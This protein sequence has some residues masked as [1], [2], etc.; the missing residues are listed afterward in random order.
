VTGGAGPRVAVVGGG[1]AGVSAAL[2][3]ADSGATVT[4]F[5]KRARL[6]GLTWS[7]SH[8]GLTMDNGQHV[9]LR[10][11]T[12]YIDFLER[13]GSW[14][15]VELQ[16][17]LDVTVLSPGP[18][19]AGPVRD[20][21]G[22]ADGAVRRSRPATATARAVLRRDRLPA[23]LHLG[24]SLLSYGLVP[25]SA[26]AR[27]AGAAL[28]LRRL[29]LDDPALDQQTFASW[30]AQ[31]G[32]GQKA[33]SALWDLIC[34]PTVNLPAERASLAMAAKVFQ[35]G[36][37]TDAS[38]GDIGWSR[39]PLGLLHGE[40]AACALRRAGVDV[41]LGETVR[42]IEPVRPGPGGS[43]AGRPA[44]G[45][46]V[47]AAGG[48]AAADGVVVAL[49]H[50]CTEDLLPPGALPDQCRPSRLAS[51]PI[52]N[53]HVRFDRRVTNLP[54]FAGLGTDAQWVFDRTESSG[55][56]SSGAGPP[57]ATSEA[58]SPGAS[59]PGT[60]SGQYLAVSISAADNYIGAR[61]EH[62]EARVLASLRQ[63][64]PGASDARVLGTLVTR[65]HHAT[66][67]ATPGSAAD[68]APT[69]TQI[70][71]LVLAGAWTA[72]GWPPTM[73]GAVRS[74][75]YAARAVLVAT[76][77]RS[78][79]PLIPDDRVTAPSRGGPRSGRGADPM[80]NG[81]PEGR[82]S[83]PDPCG[84]PPSAPNGAQPRG[85]HSFEPAKLEEVV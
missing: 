54:L 28:A 23:P 48:D 36:L 42:A 65:E 66:F 33:V 44:R 2:A 49:P 75:L 64:L 53:V 24:R 25:L 55:A 72:T 7:F 15:D 30:L 12:A 61:P 34:L 76:G 47:R 46:S 52:V 21:A 67:R 40:R 58:S 70:P 3:C 84:H 6:G 27:F 43:F 20:D 13:I 83:A 68:R 50:Y 60:G 73:E 37:L 14:D 17:R 10:C 59:S 38:A 16:E 9:F 77:Q 82:L 32:Q 4:L 63:L 19:A 51:S 5:E 41:R 80:S 8:D 56:G 62:L 78:G 74:G 35:T 81:H 26:R 45:F 11:C 57:G 22:G 85:N 39:V 71:G 69:R 79:L 1:L 29:D 18:G 31:H